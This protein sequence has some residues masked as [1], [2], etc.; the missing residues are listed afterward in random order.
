EVLPD[1][2]EVSS[3]ADL[4]NPELKGLMGLTWIGHGGSSYARGV[5]EVNEFGSQYWEHVAAVEPSIQT[6]IGN[7]VTEIERG[8]VAIGP[9][10]VSIAGNAKGQGAPIEVVL[11]DEGVPAYSQF[12]GLVDGAE[13]SAAGKVFLNWM[14]SVAGQNA[15]AKITG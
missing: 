11:P 2:I 13:N 8:E 3:W 1:D 14:S 4:T 6:S 12:V 7:L 10:A 9:A 5:Y 15:V